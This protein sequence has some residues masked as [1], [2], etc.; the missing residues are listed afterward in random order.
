M[1][2]LNWNLVICCEVKSHIL[3][4]RRQHFEGTPVSPKESFSAAILQIYMFN[5][6]LD[7]EIS[8]V[9]EFGSL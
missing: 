5:T 7:I 1:C 6:Q 3:F 9:A 2:R 4:Q 8:T